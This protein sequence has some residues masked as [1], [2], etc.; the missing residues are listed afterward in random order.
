MNEKFTLPNEEEMAKL[1]LELGKMS[2]PMEKNLFPILL[3][4]AGR[5]L[6]SPS[7][8]MVLVLAIDQYVDT[9]PTPSDIRELL[10]CL[11]I[12]RLIRSFVKDPALAKEA[13]SFFKSTTL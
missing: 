3:K 4:Q 1:L 9:L 6:N 7:L 10:H 5:E 8:V 2:S 13:N 11:L 12:P